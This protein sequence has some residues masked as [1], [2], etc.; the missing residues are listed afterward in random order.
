MDDDLDCADE[1]LRQEA[2]AS[3]LPAVRELIHAPL[4]GDISAE[5][6]IGFGQVVGIP[7][8]VRG[9]HHIVSWFR[10]RRHEHGRDLVL[11]QPPHIPTQPWL[12]RHA[13]L[14]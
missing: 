13:M 1:V 12:L 9:T 3:G 4:K 10:A 2:L 14:P 8:P 11:H 7:V 5:A 6:C